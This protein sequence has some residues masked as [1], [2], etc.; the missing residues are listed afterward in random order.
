MKEKWQ[1][2]F[3]KLENKYWMSIFFCA[4]IPKYLCE[5]YFSQEQFLSYDVK[6][7]DKIL[8]YFWTWPDSK[9]ALKASY[10]L[11]FAELPNLQ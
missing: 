6:C 7:I 5:Q 9:K 4:Y 11:P 2:L 8:Y 10:F 3:F 1:D